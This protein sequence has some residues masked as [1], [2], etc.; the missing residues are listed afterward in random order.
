L[1]AIDGRAGLLDPA[2]A[3]AV[4]DAA[5]RLV[6]GGVD[7]WTALRLG[8]PVLVDECAG[9]AARFGDLLGVM[10]RLVTGLAARGADVQNTLFYDLQRLSNE[11]ATPEAFTLFMRRLQAT[12][13]LWTE[14]GA[15]VAD[16]L[17]R[18]VTRAGPGRGA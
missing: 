5:G 4:I 6:D 8:V 2:R 12:L 7:P 13:A 18:G 17:G 3:R 16:L 11:G 15:P 14:A 1:A 9:D 10:E